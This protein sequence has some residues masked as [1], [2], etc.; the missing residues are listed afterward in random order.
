MRLQVRSFD[1]M[2]QM[3]AAGLGVAVLPRGAI[4]AHLSSMNLK[5]IALQDAWAARR[6]LIGLRDASEVPRHV[7]LLINHLC[8]SPHT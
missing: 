2:C 1:A 8:D 6:L 5:Q 7:R 3:V 4:Q